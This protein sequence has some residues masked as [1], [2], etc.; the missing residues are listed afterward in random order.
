MD[1]ALAAALADLDEA[2]QQR[3]L[4][5]GLLKQRAALER[6]V[7][8]ARTRLGDARRA[9]SSEHA[10]VARLEKLTMTRILAGLR[11]S[12][13]ADLDKE[14]AEAQAAEYAVREAESR[15][16]RAEGDLAAVG[17]RLQPLAS[18]EERLQTALTDVESRLLAG[19]DP[20]ATRLHEIAAEHGL[21]RGE[22]QQIDEAVTAAGVAARTL[23][24]ADTFLGQAGQWATYDT[25]LGGGLVGDM[26]K[27]DRLEKA[28]Q[29]IRDADAALGRLAAELAD[30][31]IS[32]V[33]PVAIDELTSFF[34]V[35]FDNI[36]S[37]W[38]VRDRIQ[39]ATERI[40]QTR[41]AVDQVGVELDRRLAANTAAEESLAAERE[42]L[43]SE[44]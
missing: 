44:R 16:Q 38:A 12:R 4:R 39:Q 19:D 18:A 30:V 36:F 6:Q 25:F 37:D 31:G 24:E 5:D 40:T 20:R 2:Q 42:R 41:Q 28:Q 14:R 3:T 11:G 35:W 7:N 43:L 23:A 17:V 32:Q 1:D 21:T 8:E 9:Y 26:M 10:D 27:Y 22:R 34:D 13:D 29:L 33:G 15:L